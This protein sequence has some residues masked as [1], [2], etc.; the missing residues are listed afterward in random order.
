MYQCSDCEKIFSK[1]GTAF[2][3]PS[4]QGKRP[5]EVHLCPFCGSSD[6][7]KLPQAYCRCCGARIKSGDYCDAACRRRGEK[8]WAAEAKRKAEYA[9][10][11]V[12]TVLRE[13]ENYNKQ[14][15]TNLSYGQYVMRRSLNDQ[16]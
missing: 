3:N 14:A 8:M 12:V 5:A 7:K 10:S 9:S 13:L 16:R 11:P 2:T 15:G 1:Y 6:F 4:G